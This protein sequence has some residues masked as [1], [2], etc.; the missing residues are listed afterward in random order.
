M[1]KVV[2]IECLLVKKILLYIRNL[3]AVFKTSVLVH[4]NMI[5]NANSI[6]HQYSI[7]KCVEFAYAGICNVRNSTGLSRII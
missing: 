4:T 5:K 2:K 1:I 6:E 7:N 3:F